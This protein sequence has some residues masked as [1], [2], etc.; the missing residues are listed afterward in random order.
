MKLQ[1]LGMDIVG[2]CNLKCVGCPNSTLDRKIRFTELDDFSKILNNIDVSHVEFFKLYNFGESFLHP[3]IGKFLAII[4]KQKWSVK[5]IELSTNGQIVDEEKI[6]SVLS[7][8]RVTRFGIS[9]DGDCTPEEYE[10]LRSGAKWEKLINFMEM[11]S[12]IHIDCGSTAKMF[13]KIICTGNKK[14]WKVLAG[15]YGF[16]IEW[17][18]WR[19]PP[20]A[21]MFEGQ[22]K[23][24]LHKV[25]KYV[26]STKIRCFV[27]W[28]GLVVPC[29]CHP[30][31]AVLGNLLKERFTDI[32]H[33]SKRKAFI[34]TMRRNR[35]TMKICGNCEIK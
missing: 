34:R 23:R 17:L 15:K 24:S 27:G 1:R 12:R 5:H 4:P 3:D 31:A 35:P 8:K 2:G 33:G 7:N 13:L 28:D 16:S 29:C 20:E 11:S 32:Y 18:D 10:R 19:R 26:K 25:C 22:Q 30:R 14:E 6:R 21:K 9:A